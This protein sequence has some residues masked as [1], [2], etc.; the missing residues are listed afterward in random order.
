[1]TTPFSVSRATT[2]RLD[3]VMRAGYLQSSQI[4]SSGR[5]TPR[6]HS[7]TAPSTMDMDMTSASGDVGGAWRRKGRR[8]RATQDTRNAKPKDRQ[9]RG[10][11]GKQGAC[12][13]HEPT[14][15]TSF[16]RGVCLQ[17]TLLTGGGRS[18]AGARRRMLRWH[19]LLSVGKQLQ[20]GQT[21]AT[22]AGKNREMLGRV[23]D[24][25]AG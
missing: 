7:G 13:G 23:E 15:P 19:R 9:G 3:L 1:M 12:G 24:G 5:K 16:G 6:G 8:D 17:T 22:R 21:I 25:M 18:S 10:W 20:A 4:V 14:H 11:S 2:A